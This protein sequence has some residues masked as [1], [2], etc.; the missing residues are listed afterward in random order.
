[1]MRTP[2]RLAAASAAAATLVVTAA[3]AT[4]EP[5][6][7]TPVPATAVAGTG[8]S[9]VDTGSAAGN[10][11]LYFLGHGDV[12]GVLV[13]LITTPFAILTGGVCD[14]ATLSA[15]PSPCTKAP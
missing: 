10:S 11:A 15:L 3:G 1:M 8:S 2:L 12:I 5:T 6:G 7:S 9:A 4:A 13:L 14:L